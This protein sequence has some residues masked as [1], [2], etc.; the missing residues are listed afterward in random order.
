[1]GKRDTEV[2]KYISGIKDIKIPAIFKILFLPIFGIFLSLIGFYL[3]YTKYYHLNIIIF[4]LM[5]IIFGILALIFI[6]IRAYAPEFVLELIKIKFFRKANEC[7]IF[8]VDELGIMDTS[9][10][11]I[12]FSVREVK[13]K[14]TGLRYEFS[15][16]DVVYFNRVPVLFVSGISGRAIPAKYVN[17]LNLL[18]DLGFKTVKDVKRFIEEHE[19]RI[20]E[21]LKRLNK[22][23]SEYQV[24]KDENIK[25]EIE[26]LEK[27]LEQERNLIKEIEDAISTIPAQTMKLKNVVKVLGNENPEIKMAKA[28]R[29]YLAGYIRG[30]K[31]EGFIQ[32]LKWITIIAIIL[33]APTITYVIVKAMGGL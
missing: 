6:L 17:S 13:D 21:K 27:E 15:D 18:K 3:L 4:G 16:E 25:L 14:A 2:Y 30:Q 31:D 32:I 23:K 1:M 24:L 8:F 26:K 22:L 19:K 20:G 9:V 5:I 10:G 12:D 28:Q 33:A 29:F 11:E 7:I